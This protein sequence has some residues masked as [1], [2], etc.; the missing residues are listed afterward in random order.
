MNGSHKLLIA[1]ISRHVIFKA[2]IAAGLMILCPGGCV[3]LP[4]QRVTSPVR[5]W[6]EHIFAFVF[7]VMTIRILSIPTISS[8]A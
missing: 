8:R 4:S 3:N 1:C 6:P 5:A 2:L 7:A